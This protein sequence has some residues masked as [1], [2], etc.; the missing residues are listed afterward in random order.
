MIYGSGAN[1]HILECAGQ[2]TKV[3][4]SLGPH[5]EDILSLSLSSDSTLLACG[6]SNTAY[7]HNLTTGVQTTLRGLPSKSST[8]IC[9]FHTHVRTRLLVGHCDQLFVYDTTR[10]S[11]PSK[12]I[13]MG[14][15][16][17]CVSAIACSPFSK[18]LVAITLSNG[19]VGLVDL[20]KEKA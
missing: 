19:F 14:N 5:K 15:A 16:G 8:V 13:P 11:A 10:P 12:M 7:V 2:T 6:L 4:Q 17:T 3:V 1:I 18:S 9:M 20:D